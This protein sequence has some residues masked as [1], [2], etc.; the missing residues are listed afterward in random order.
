[1]YP[2]MDAPLDDK[3][4]CVTRFPKRYILTILGF[5]GFANFFAVRFNFPIG[6]RGAQEDGVLVDITSVQKGQLLSAFFMGYIVTQIPAGVVARRHGGKWPFAVGIAGAAL[7]GFLSP[8]AMKWGVKETMFVQLISGLF[9]GFNFP[10]MHELLS[11]WSPQHERSKLPCIV[12]SGTYFGAVFANLFGGYI[13]R[14]VG[15]QLVFVIDSSVAI[16]WLLLWVYFIYDKPRSHPS[17]Q[18]EELN[19]IELSMG[20]YSSEYQWTSPVP[21]FSIWTSAPFWAIVAAHFVQNWGFFTLLSELPYYF[22]DVYESEIGSTGVLTAAPFAATLVTVVIGGISLD[23]MR[24]EKRGASTTVVRKT[25]VCGA[26]T[27][28]ALLFISAVY[29]SSSGGSL[30]CIV[31]A[32]GLSGISAAGFLPNHLDIAPQY[33]GILMGITGTAGTIP[34]IASPMVTGIIVKHSSPEEWQTV[35]YVA[36]VVYV[37]GAIVFGTFASSD[38]QKWAMDP[39]GEDDEC[40]NP[41]T[42]SIASTQ[43]SR[44]P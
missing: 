6:L 16:L 19:E 2:N 3:R 26:F 15:W 7:C 35:F 13:V 5:L 11:R 43:I 9:Q 18:E 27:G 17:I 40:F 23:Y 31:G 30:A 12:Y 20:S 25:A 4:S 44:C 24:D 36:A 10:A 28:A 22:K 34:G 32:T 1:M 41:E 33:A 21:W 37:F 42:Q 14:S 39:N 8:L 38:T 29:S